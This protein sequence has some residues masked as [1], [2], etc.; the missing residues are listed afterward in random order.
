MH[1]LRVQAT[2]PVGSPDFYD[3][4]FAKLSQAS[5]QELPHF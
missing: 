4:E 3:P 2:R 1:Q 5:A